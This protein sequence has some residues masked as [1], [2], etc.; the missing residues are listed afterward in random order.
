MDTTIIK[1]YKGAEIEIIVEDGLITTAKIYVGYA[2]KKLIEVTEDDFP[3]GVPYNENYIN[4]LELKFKNY[5]DQLF[6]SWAS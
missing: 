4:Q 5:I 1:N 2:C 3:N 6:V